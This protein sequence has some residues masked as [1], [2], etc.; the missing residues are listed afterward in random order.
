MTS[1]AQKYCWGTNFV[2]IL[3]SAV[4]S[5][6]L[7]QN[8]PKLAW[9]RSEG[10][11]GKG[12]GQKMSWQSVPL[13]PIGFVLRAPYLPNQ[14]P[15]FL[16]FRGHW[17]EGR[18]G[19]GGGPLTKRG[20]RGRGPLTKR[21]WRGRD[22]F[23]MTGEEKAYTALLQWGTCL[24]RKKW[25][26]Q[27]KDFGGRYGLLGFQ[28]AFVSTTGLESFTLQPEKFPKRFSFGGGRVRF[29]FSVMTFSDVF[30]FPVPFLASPF[31]LRLSCQMM[32]A[33][34]LSPTLRRGPP[35]ISINLR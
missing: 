25:G 12:T 34:F 20:W 24:C 28:R 1:V 22:R 7:R 18:R 9:W 15:S 21:G 13:T 35:L 26:P 4:L 2:R 14:L 11:A 5:R 3:A 30:F 10:D 32:E 16:Y 6:S 27:R 23:V 31:D 29:F 33:F 17:W 19:G 8:S